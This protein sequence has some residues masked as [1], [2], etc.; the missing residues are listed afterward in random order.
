MNDLQKVALILAVFIGVALYFNVVSWIISWWSGWRTLAARFRHDF[1]SLDQIG[2]WKSARMRWGC[3]YNN[4]LKIAANED[5]LS[6]ATIAIV[7]QHP[8]LLIPWGEI[9]VVKRSTMLWWTFVHLELGTQERI[10][11]IIY[12]SIFAAANRLGKLETTNLW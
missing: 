12:E 5:G 4:A 10:P 8:P 1:N 3:H 2:F 11:F 9:R 6:L 7:F